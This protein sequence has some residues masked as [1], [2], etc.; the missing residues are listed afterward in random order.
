[1]TG[2]VKSDTI[3][4]P[5][6]F[7]FVFLGEL[8]ILFLLSRVLT[9][10]LSFLLYRLTHSKRFTVYCMAFLFF[11]GTVI[12]EMSHFLAAS[13]LFVGT[14]RI[15][16]LPKM[17]GDTVKLGSVEIAKTDPARRFFIGAA[18]FLLGTAII[19]SVLFY[20][21]QN[22]F[23]NSPG[24]IGIT[25]YVLFEIGNTMY[26]SKKDREGT[27][28][29][30]FAASVLLVL[31]YLFGVRVELAPGLRDTFAKLFEKACWYL[32]LPITLNTLV[33][34]FLR[35]TKAK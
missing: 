24:M 12:H 14:G 23:F 20:M 28:E 30:V 10:E 19:V 11:P 2:I 27:L 32:T 26:S 18:P 16:L 15:D 9:Q 4:L 33:I 13:V 29:L 7:A 22:S 1:M 25:A 6:I 8:L 17:E 31:F 35:F 5:M 21:E 3:A 34:G